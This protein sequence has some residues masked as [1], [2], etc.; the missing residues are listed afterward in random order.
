MV[1][2]GYTA[3]YRTS[4]AVLR[5]SELDFSV[6]LVAPQAFCLHAISSNT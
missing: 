6:A 2:G 3:Q 1:D 4:R 5:F